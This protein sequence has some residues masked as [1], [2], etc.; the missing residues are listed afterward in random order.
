M[1]RVVRNSGVDVWLTELTGKSYVLFVCEILISEKH[2]LVVKPSR[3]NFINCCLTKLLAQVDTSDLSTNPRGN[4][5]DINSVHALRLCVCPLN[6]A[7]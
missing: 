6:V 2:N 3:S 1:I 7:D 5:A 4:R